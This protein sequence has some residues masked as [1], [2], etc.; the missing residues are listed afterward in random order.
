MDL[1]RLVLELK[2]NH[3]ALDCIGQTPLRIVAG[4]QLAFA[5]QCRTSRRPAV[6]RWMSFEPKNK[7]KYGVTSL[8]LFQE[9]HRRLSAEGHGT[10]CPIWNN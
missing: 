1:V 6:G 3:N 2:A 8:Q 5:C 9:M 10:R 4:C 7:N